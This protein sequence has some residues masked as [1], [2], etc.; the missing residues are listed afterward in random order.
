[1]VNGSLVL[2]LLVLSCG[3][4]PQHVATPTPF[5]SASPQVAPGE[6]APGF[7]KA[8]AE[9]SPRPPKPVPLL[10]TEVQGLEALL[11]A[12][13]RQAHDRPLLLHRLF[14]NYLE[15]SASAKQQQDAAPPGSPEAAKSDNLRRSA[16]EGAGR[17]SQTLAAE[18]PGFTP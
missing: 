16:L 10:V 17:C 5:E 3:G 11:A 9:V 15:L 4:E 6:I 7:P 8:W 12:T 18:A 14:L 2:G 13:P 1:L